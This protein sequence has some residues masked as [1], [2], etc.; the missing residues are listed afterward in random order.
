MLFITIKILRSDNQEI[1]FTS[2]SLEN[3]KFIRNQNNQKEYIIFDFENE[4][5]NVLRLDR[6]VSDLIA[7]IEKYITLFEERTNSLKVISDI[8]KGLDNTVLSI[9]SF[10]KVYNSGGFSDKSIM[11]N[12]TSEL[13]KDCLYDKLFEKN[14]CFK[15]NINANIL[16][17]LKVILIR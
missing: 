1:L 16:E 17:K 12:K 14:R 3:N 15:D 13:V 7:T 5:E 9:K 6:G 8:T 10:H 2:T 4:K 11:K